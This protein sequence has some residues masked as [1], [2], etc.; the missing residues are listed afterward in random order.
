MAGVKAKIFVGKWVCDYRVWKMIKGRKLSLPCNHKN[1]LFLSVYANGSVRRSG[2]FCQHYELSGTI[3]E[4]DT[5][6]NIL[7]SD[8]LERIVAE[9]RKVEKAI[10]FLKREKMIRSR[11]ETLID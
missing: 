3:C 5:A 6:L 2:S 1:L 4:I 10:D 8:C 7:K 11:A 9:K